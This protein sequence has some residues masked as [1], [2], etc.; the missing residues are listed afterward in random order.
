LSFF[1]SFTF[2]EMVPAQSFFFDP[3]MKDINSA[4][5]SGGD[6]ETVPSL[7]SSRDWP[8]FLFHTSKEV[9]TGQASPF[10]VRRKR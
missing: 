8:F 2:A 4:F 5:G 6:P 3:V 9:S 10:F 1:L 7:F